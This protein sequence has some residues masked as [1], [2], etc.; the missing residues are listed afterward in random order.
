MN[1]NRAR[2][3]ALHQTGTPTRAIAVALGITHQAVSRHMNILGLAP[4]VAPSPFQE[5]VR[6]LHALGRTTA[7]MA[8]ELD[9]PYDRVFYLLRRMGLPINRDHAPSALHR[10][11]WDGHRAGKTTAELARE[12]AIGFLQVERMVRELG[13]PKQGATQLYGVHVRRLHGA[14]ACPAAIAST[15]G[16]PTETVTDVL[17]A[18]GL[19]RFSRTSL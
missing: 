6:A 16:I 9:L 7:A 3:F 8:A 1:P 17:I 11:V 18:L 10:A 4:N 13:L 15:L 14:G 5:E 2:V 19:K 12:L